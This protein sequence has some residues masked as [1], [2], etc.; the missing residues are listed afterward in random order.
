MVMSSNAPSSSLILL[1]LLFARFACI[2]TVDGVVFPQGQGKTKKE[3]KTHAAKNAF[4]E[5]LGI[6]EPDEETG[7]TLILK[8]VWLQVFLHIYLCTSNDCNIYYFAFYDECCCEM[9]DER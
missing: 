3:A 4:A 1:C 9:R 7:K 5:I 8:F 2:C 6:E